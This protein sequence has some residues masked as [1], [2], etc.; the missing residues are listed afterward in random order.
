MLV[1]VRQGPL[2]LLISSVSMT[3]RIFS[4]P[5]QVDDEMISHSFIIVAGGGDH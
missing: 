5:P 2:E 4:M 3:H 1:P